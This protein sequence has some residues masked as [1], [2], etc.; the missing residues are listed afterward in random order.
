MT[1]H[2]ATGGQ[3]N[4]DSARGEG[5][6]CGLEGALCDRTKGQDKYTNTGV[7]EAD[8]VQLKCSVEKCRALETANGDEKRALWE[9][10]VLNQG[11]SLS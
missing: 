10:F 5:K 9:S 1:Y 8:G 2:G 7:I 3:L 6:L 4:T 11:E